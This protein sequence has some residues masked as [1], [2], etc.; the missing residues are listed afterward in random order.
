MIIL[1]IILGELHISGTD[2]FRLFRFHSDSKSRG[3]KTKTKKVKDAKDEADTV[4]E[5]SEVSG[6][7]KKVKKNRKGCKRLSSLVIGC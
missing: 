1:K 2:I 4:L 6:P 7:K 3:M 5:D